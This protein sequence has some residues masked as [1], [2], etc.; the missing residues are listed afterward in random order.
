MSTLRRITDLFLHDA[1]RLN[2]EQIRVFDDVLCLLVEKIEKTALA[3]LG[4][5]LAPVN[6]AP[7][8]LV[9]RLARDEEI[10]VAAPVLKDSKRLSAADLV[11]IAQTRSQ[12]HL[13]AISERVVVDSKVTDVL[14]VRGDQKVLSSLAKNTGAQF[15]ESGFDRLV[16]RAEGD[17]ELCELVGLR[18]D[19]PKNLLQELLRRAADT[20]L[21]KILAL[22]PPER[23]K[24]IENII[25]KIGRTISKITEKD[26]SDAQN[27]VAALAASGRLNDDALLR[28][29]QKRQSDEMIVALA[30]LSAT[31]I[32][33]IAQLIN[34]HRNDA[35]L[36]PCKVADLRW[37][38]VELILRDRLLGQAAVDSIIEIA[39][40][41]YAKLTP[42]TAQRALRFMS[43]R[44]T[45]S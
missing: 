11:D 40:K 15:S 22:L 14:V 25:I 28:F 19:L 21:A 35:F 42:S 45:V 10:T 12:A 1:G 37:P 9:K 44:E 6:M 8:Q 34:G 7:L 36:L 24:E 39:R 29:A 17:N 16:K 32:K 5:R 4:T 3:E 43:V 38:T 33:I 27:T 41:D 26:Y 30:R 2:D 20:V 13:L 23:R 18:R 31:S